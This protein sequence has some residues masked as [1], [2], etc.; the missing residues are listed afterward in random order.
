MI[1]WNK[2][3]NPHQQQAIINK[4]DKQKCLINMWCGTGK[5]R[6]FTISLFQDNLDINVIVFPSLG[7]INQY[8]NDYFLNQDNIFKDNFYKF[9]CLAFCS[10]SDTKLKLKTSTIR[11]STSEKTCKSFMKKKEK[12]IV[13]VTYQSFEKFINICIDIDIQIDRLI[14]DEAHHIVGDKTQDIVF[15]NNKLN[16]IVSKT[17]F[18]T[19]TP[20]NKNGIVMY[21]RD[22]PDNSD[23][24]V[25]ACEYLY[26]QAVE[27]K[28]CKA[29]TTNISL[30]CQKPEY[31]NKYQPIFEL[32]IRACLSG[33]YDYWN[34]LTYHSYV[35][36]NNYG[37][38]FVKDFI[39]PKNQRLLKS[40]F[41][42]IQDEEFPH[43]KSL[44]TIENVKLGGIYTTIKKREKILED[45]DRKVEGRIYILASCNTLNE[46]IDT[47]WANMGIPINPSQSIVKESQRIGRLVRTPEP[48]MPNSVILIPCLID[49]TKYDNLDDSHEQDKMIRQELSETGN[50]NAALNVISAFKYQYDSELFEMCLKYPNMYSPKEVKENLEKHNLN[51]EESKRD[52]I[53]NIKYICNKENIEIE[54]NSKEGL[55][56]TELLNVVALEADKTIEIHTQDYDT[57]IEYINEESDDDI[58]LRLFRDE[59]NNY[60]PII[61]NKNK[62]INKRNINPPKKRKPILNI[63][64][65]P[66]L[67]VLWKIDTT[68][69]NKGFGQ[70]ILDVKIDRN[71]HKW[72]DTLQTVVKYIN[73][74]DKR[75]SNSDKDKEIKQLGSWLSTQKTNY[76]KK[77]YIMKEPEIQKEWERF[78]DKYSK[79][80]QDNN[81]IWKDT[82]QTVSQY[83]DENDKRPP[84]NDK[85]KE[86]KQ[87]GKWLSDQKTKYSK[88]TDIMKKPEIQKEWETF[89]DK[90]SKYFQDNITIWKDNLQTVSQYIDENDKRPSQYDKNKEIKQLGKW[91]SHQKTN[92]SKKTQIMKEP[93]IQ[94][95]WETFTYKYSKY[96]DKKTKKKN[97]SKPEIQ[98]KTETTN[99]TISNKPKPKSV[100]SELHQKYK[101]M[102]SQNLHNHFQENQ[103]DWKSYHKISKENEESFPEEEIPR[104]RIINKLE[105]LPGKKKKDVVDLGCGYGEI[106]QHFKN[107]N[108]FSFQNFDHVS[109]NEYVISRDIKDTRLDDS[110]IDIAIMCLSM[111]GSNC[112]DYLKEV[113]RILDTGGTL[114]IVEAYKR[115]NDNDENKNRLVELLEQNKFKVMEQIDEKFM[116]IECRK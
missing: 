110:S 16:N 109:C 89:T 105:N 70:G 113:C 14:F 83:I 77:T 116:Y 21:D 40:R 72:K 61:S 43:T 78:T 12:K 93:E 45:F 59:N 74:N 80:F 66:D 10:D 76:S 48:N 115:W 68:K 46:G 99:N 11:Y 111:W 37:D 2:H 96:F 23:C 112:K 88:K 27:D 69:L 90:Y 24:G 29:F 73:E 62:K 13:L 9:Q 103:N 71:Q 50:F 41:T 32:I 65:H 67:D 39:S 22:E 3:L 57:P 63:H 4:R 33:E 60:S 49:I 55:N 102:N 26:Y 51:V 87:L 5:T 1:K 107:N 38:S 8:N 30:Y 85:D 82:L 84:Y 108:R 42:K 25:L 64:T 7:L 34:I 53:D 79:Y 98:S 100:L 81:T 31:K 18:Y 58:P 97:M 20:V 75:P 94:K 44:F 56:E 36:E 114:Y 6:T 47:K 35:N 28:I 86:I 95:E 17:E 91:L 15:N 92:Y 19:A 106:S 52:L 104:N 54:F 101:T